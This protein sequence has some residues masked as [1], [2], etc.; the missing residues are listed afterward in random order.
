MTI[1]IYGSRQQE[2]YAGEIADF[3]VALH[4][5]GIEVVMHRKIHGVLSALVPDALRGVRS[6][7]DDF[8]FEAD[9]AMSFGG[10]GTFLR[11]AMWVGDRQL[12]ILGV[13]T[14]HLGY[15]SGASIDELPDV[16]LELLHG[17]FDIESRSLIEAE[18]HGCDAALDWPYALNEVTFTK[19][20]ASSIV[21]AQTRINGRDLASYR[22][23]GLIVATPTGST[24]YNLSVGGPVVQPTAP[25]WVISPIA[26]HSLGMRPLVVSDDTEL[27]VVVEARSR[28]FRLTLDGRYRMLPVGTRVSLRRAPFVTRIIMRRAHAFPAALR[29]KL[30]WN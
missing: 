2:P 4:A 17:D 15:L 12:P 7:A 13:N 8:R 29:E 23:D 11:T 18:V 10:D 16:L 9:M 19:D 22:A 21:T 26:A 5:A 24:A 25:V 6:V 3:L 30:N 1:A 14:G 20:E 28:S 27:E